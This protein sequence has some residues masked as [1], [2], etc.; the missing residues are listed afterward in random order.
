MLI[1]KIEIREIPPPRACVAIVRSVSG[2]SLRAIRGREP[3]PPPAGR[4]PHLFLIF[5][6][7][8][9]YSLFEKS[10][11]RFSWNLSP[12][13]PRGHPPK[14]R[15]RSVSPIKR[16]FSISA[17]GNFSSCGTFRPSDTLS[18][19]SSRAIE[20]FHTGFPRAGRVTNSDPRP[21]SSSPRIGRGNGFP[22]TDPRNGARSSGVSRP[23]RTR[24]TCIFTFRGRKLR[25]V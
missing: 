8:S 1:P 18:K 5:L 12:L 17:L 11:G 4:D 20:T 25:R 21:R 9:F 22:S 24:P 2:S 23:Y 16:N 19:P 14:T 6:R 10:P 3:P 15:A 13:L 7:R